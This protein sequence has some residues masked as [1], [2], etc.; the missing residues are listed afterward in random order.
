MVRHLDPVYPRIQPF[1]LDQPFDGQQAR[2]DHMVLVDVPLRGTAALSDSFVVLQITPLTR[3][4]IVYSYRDTHD[5][6]HPS[7]TARFG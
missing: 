3:D 4:I 5:L 6:A 1:S 7:T 2:E